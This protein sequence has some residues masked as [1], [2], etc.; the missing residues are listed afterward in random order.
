MHDRA[1]TQSSPPPAAGATAAPP[2]PTARSLP[3]RA[4]LIA[5]DIKLAH[6]IFALPFA[7]LGGALAAAD[8]DLTAGPIAARFALITVCMVAAR[9]WAMLVNRLADRTFDAKNPRTATR[10]FA[11][12]AVDT[13]TGYAALVTSAAVFL[14]ASAAFGPAFGNWW[15]IVGAPPILAWLA[16]YSFTKRFTA[17]CHLVLGVALALS[18]IA[19]AIAV[20]G[21]DAVAL[22]NPAAPNAPAIWAIAAM[23]AP[24]V[25]G[26]DVIYALADRDFDRAQ[27]LRSLPAALGW[28]G[29]AN[30]A[31]A[32]HLAAA[33]ALL[34]AWR[35]GPALGVA[36]AVAALITVGLLITEHAVL[37][38]RRE[39]GLNIAFFTLNGVVAVLLGVAG[40]V[41]AAR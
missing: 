20:A 8:A 17:A 19:A 26:F 13:R 10:A 31:R 22:G 36:F 23:I 29:A 24:W 39:R 25:A 27:G 32:L 12:G 38:I 14:I 30:A 34:I 40:V 16:F 2:T 7:V 35:V 4:A 11:S 9:T 41:D 5:A 3:H 37:A 33:I 18:P 21:L 6:S 1:A 15:P 28:N